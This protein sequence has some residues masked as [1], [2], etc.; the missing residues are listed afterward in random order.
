MV[1]KKTK[2]LSEKQATLLMPSSAQI[3]LTVRTKSLCL[4]GTLVLL[5]RKADDVQIDKPLPASAGTRSAAPIATVDCKQCK[6]V[7]CLST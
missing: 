3:L 4:V 7:H 5:N 2:V 1:N 6:H